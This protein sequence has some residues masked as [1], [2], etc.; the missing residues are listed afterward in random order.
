MMP[1]GHGGY[2]GQCAKGMCTGRAAPLDPA[3]RHLC[4]V[5]SAPVQVVVK[6][7]LFTP[8]WQ[9]TSASCKLVVQ[10]RDQGDAPEAT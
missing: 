7:P 3:V 4:H 8:V 2:C 10:P 6:V 5:C 9:W 1:C